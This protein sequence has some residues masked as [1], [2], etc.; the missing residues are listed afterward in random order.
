MREYWQ[1][2]ADTLFTFANISDDGDGEVIADINGLTTAGKEYLASNELGYVYFPSHTSGDAADIKLIK[3]VIGD[4]TN[5]LLAGT[6]VAMVE[7]PTQN[8]GAKAFFNLDTLDTVVLPHPFDKDAVIGESAFG[9][10]ANLS[11]TST[12]NS[13]YDKWVA[14]E[15]FTIPEGVKE[16]GGGAFDSCTS[17]N[18]K[19]VIPASLKTTTTSVVAPFAT[20]NI[21]QFSIIDGATIIPSRIFAQCSKLTSVDIPE[22]VTE[23]QE[24]A[25]FYDTALVSLDI[26][27]SVV[28]MSASGIISGC[29]ALTTINYGGKKAAFTASGLTKQGIPQAITVHCSDGDLTL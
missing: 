12:Y 16:L 25:F 22:S 27:A 20:T 6:E 2:N 7:I 8:I 9:H 17:L 28:T 23:I 24:N 4:G 26:P 21:T 29:T 15:F 13:I 3:N 18:Y 14:N 1:D 10:C 19:V 11:S 5:S